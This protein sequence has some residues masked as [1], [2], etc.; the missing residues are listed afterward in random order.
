[1]IFVH[2]I[3]RVFDRIRRVLDGDHRRRRPARPQHPGSR[4]PPRHYRAARRAPLRRRPGLPLRRSAR[5]RLAPPHLYL[6]RKRSNPVPSS[7]PGGK[8]APPKKPPLSVRRRSSGAAAA[9][10]S[11]AETR[12]IR[13]TGS[14]HSDPLL[15]RRILVRVT[16]RLAYLLSSAPRRPF[17]K[18]P[19]GAFSIQPRRV[20]V[21]DT[22]VNPIP[23]APPL[24][25]DEEI[26][27]EMMK[28]IATTTGYGRTGTPGAGFQG[29]TVS[30]RRRLRQ[31]SHRPLRPVPRRHSSQA[32]RS[33]RSSGAPCF[34]QESFWQDLLLG[35]AIF[36]L[37]RLRVPKTLRALRA[38]SFRSRRQAPFFPE[39]SSR[40]PAI[41][42]EAGYCQPLHR[43]VIVQASAG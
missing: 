2:D 17:F 34:A 31:T 26:A 8:P 12:I 4:A 13:E 9:P 5:G 10:I 29:G 14:G 23:A 28:F 3:E 30:R 7:R 21:S 18:A 25:R 24:R 20:P 35:I 6:R 43:R 42:L 16:H 32:L 22:P 38:A 36:P 41:D 39:R 15:Y 37:S 27:L 40:H 1:M 19:H 11:I 33:A